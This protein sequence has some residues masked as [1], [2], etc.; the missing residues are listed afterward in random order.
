MTQKEMGHP[1]LIK[2]WLLMELTQVLNQ[3][4]HFEHD[5]IP[6]KYY[7]LVWLE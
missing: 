4:E 6:E 5:N 3:R 2:S 7:A 1:P